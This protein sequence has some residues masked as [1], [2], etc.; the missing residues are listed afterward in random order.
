MEA[1]TTRNEWS[2]RASQAEL[3]CIAEEEEHNGPRCDVKEDDVA[4]QKP[5]DVRR[6][7]KK[8]RKRKKKRRGG[9]E[10]VGGEEG[11]WLHLLLI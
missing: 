1:H 11:G 4:E 8:K 2:R 10:A 6:K 5:S 3:N 7:G 9:G